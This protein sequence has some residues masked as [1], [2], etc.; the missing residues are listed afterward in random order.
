LIR[1][2]SDDPAMMESCERY[3]RDVLSE[4]GSRAVEDLL[5][6]AKMRSGYFVISAAI[7]EPPPP[8][9]VSDFGSV[10]NGP[11]GV[12]VTIDPSKEAGL[13]SILSA[14]K[15]SYAESKVKVVSRYEVTVI[16]A[17]VDAVSQIIIVDRERDMMDEVASVLVSIAPEGFRVSRMW[18]STR[19][20][21]ILCSQHSLKKAWIDEAERIHSSWK[22]ID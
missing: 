14:L 5:I 13:P 4:S 10:E 18:K 15:A 17:D 11:E 2:E 19:A 16:G 22:R 8:S 6:V 1:C 7:R 12:A 20:L 21:T 3:A 9:R